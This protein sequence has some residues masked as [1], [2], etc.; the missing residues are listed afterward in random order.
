MPQR[1]VRFFDKAV[2]DGS[3]STASC[4]NKNSVFITLLGFAIYDFFHFFV[5]CVQGTM[6]A[7]EHSLFHYPLLQF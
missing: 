6:G 7:V 3:S 2:W 5:Y 1:T 4:A